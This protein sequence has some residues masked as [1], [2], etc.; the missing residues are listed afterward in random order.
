MKIKMYKLMEQLVQSGIDAGFA[1]AHKHTETPREETI[2]SCIEA[3]TMALLNE[4]FTF[5]QEEL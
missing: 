5:E 4:Y 2:K 1:R 3:D